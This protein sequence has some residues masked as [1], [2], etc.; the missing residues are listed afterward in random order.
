MFL[1]LF[2]PTAERHIC[3]VFATFPFLQLKKIKCDYSLKQ[4]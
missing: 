4:V 3:D 2:N 1:T